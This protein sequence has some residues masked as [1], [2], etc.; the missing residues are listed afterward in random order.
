MAQI[1]LK[2][3]TISFRDGDS[4]TPNEIAVTVGQGNLTYVENRAI[5]YTL[6]RGVLDEVRLGDQAPLEVS[7]SFTWTYIRGTMAGGSSSTDFGSAASAGSAVPT[8]EDVLKQKGAAA[9][10]V[11]SDSDACRPYCVDIVVVYTPPCTGD[12]ETIIL[13]DFRYEQLSHDLSAGTISVSGK[14][15]ATEALADRDAQ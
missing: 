3:A 15:N 12:M 5:E 6:D 7:L 10:W 1:D 8:V 9:S 14:C 13:P 2:N 11:S 4:P